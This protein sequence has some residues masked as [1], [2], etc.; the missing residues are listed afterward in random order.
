MDTDY[1]LPHLIK[2]AELFYEKKNQKYCYAK[3]KG[4]MYEFGWKHKKKGVK[5]LITKEIAIYLTIH[6]LPKKK[7]K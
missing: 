7:K 3:R 5:N 1:I 6:Q 2:W 4:K